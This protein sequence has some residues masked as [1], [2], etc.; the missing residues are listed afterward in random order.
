MKKLLSLMV[1]MLFGGINMAHGNIVSDNVAKLKN[2]NACPRCDL[3]GANLQEAD[4]R[5]ANLSRAN[6]SR[7]NLSGAYLTR[8][9]LGEADLQ[10]TN[11]TGAHLQRADLSGA[12]W[13]DGRT[14]AQGSIGVCK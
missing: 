6:L 3:S 2:T 12:T 4:L 5:D 14:C 13:T 10:G 7:A 9:Y 8:A 1:I 11:L